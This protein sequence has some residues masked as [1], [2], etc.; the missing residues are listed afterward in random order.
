MGECTKETAFTIMDT[1]Y[2]NGGNFIDTQVPL[3]VIIE[4]FKCVTEKK[5]FQLTI[6]LESSANN[7][8][9]EQSE[10]WVGEWMRMRQ[11]RDQMVQGFSI[12]QLIETTKR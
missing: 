8:Q 2:K 12:P 7:Y 3:A 6:C 4:Q 11:N 5:I 1:F 10:E 9:A